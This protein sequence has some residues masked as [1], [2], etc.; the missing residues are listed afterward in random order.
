MKRLVSLYTPKM[1][2]I[3]F[4]FQVN[5]YSPQQEDT[6]NYKNTNV[7]VLGAL[8]ISP[9]V[10]MLYTWF[11]PKFLCSQITSNQRNAFRSCDQSQPISIEQSLNFNQFTLRWQR[12]NITLYLENKLGFRQTKCLCYSYGYKDNNPRIKHGVRSA[13]IRF[14]LINFSCG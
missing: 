3:N 12:S 2:S 11:V 6:I 13:W 10:H 14:Y 4:I 7:D 1:E 8:Y 9:D 5:V